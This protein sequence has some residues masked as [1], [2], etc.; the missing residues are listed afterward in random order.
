M[1][2]DSLT[3]NRH[4]MSGTHR[5]IPSGAS[6]APGGERGK[7]HKIPFCKDLV[8]LRHLATSPKLVLVEKVCI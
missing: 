6:A 2:F 5:D 4:A 3:T 7:V 1:H 8:P